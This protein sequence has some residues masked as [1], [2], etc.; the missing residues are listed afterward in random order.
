MAVC[1]EG[2]SDFLSQ[3][4]VCGC[5]HHDYITLHSRNGNKTAEKPKSK[6]NTC[7]APNVTKTLA[8]KCTNDT[9]ASEVSNQR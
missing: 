5:G 1:K 2:N 7:L 4:T 9:Y 3:P 6:M 8:I